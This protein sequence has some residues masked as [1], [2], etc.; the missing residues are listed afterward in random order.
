MTAPRWHD[1]TLRIVT[2]AFLGTFPDEAVK[3]DRTTRQ[4]IPFP[5]PS[6]RGALGY[7]LRALAGAH[8]GNDLTAL[9]TAESAV[10]GAART[11]TTGGPSPLLLRGPR[12]GLTA[13]PV[14]QAA[15]GTKYLLGPGLLGSPPPRCL[16][17][18][19]TLNLRVKN[20][21]TALHADLFLAALWGLRTF[22]G[23]GA[24]TRR[25]LGTLAVT[26]VPALDT[27]HFDPAWLATDSPSDLG[28]VLN[29]VRNVLNDLAIPT[30]PNQNQPRYPCFAE[31]H[32]TTAPDDDLGSGST[33]NALATTGE[34]W[35][36]FRLGGDRHGPGAARTA[37][38]DT[39]A[40]PFLDGG[41][42]QA[43]L[44][45]GALGLPIPYQDKR[46]GRTAIAETVLDGAPARRASPI[47]LRV[48]K[49]GPAWKLRSLAFHAEWLPPEANLRIRNPKTHHTIN[50]TAPTPEQIRTEINR[51]FHHPD[52]T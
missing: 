18:G 22:G 17:D 16:P 13:Y 9:L 39:V 2:P 12:I 14:K 23:L 46:A 50:I 33:A 43:P 52:H 11:A 49:R 24:R 44:L 41:H 10:F 21:G 26:T 35:R 19:T 8:L 3:G 45:A 25:G 5:I 48:T 7:W 38:Y 42:P 31:N 32:Y 27:R 6:L 37:T 34:W 36:N 20:T 29:C 28:A 40:K 1:L 51:W 4:T 30:T 15:F 47:W